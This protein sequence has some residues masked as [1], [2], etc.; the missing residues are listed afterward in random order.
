MITFLNVKSDWR[1]RAVFF[2]S[3]PICVQKNSFDVKPLLQQV[4]LSEW[5]PRLRNRS[6][7]EELLTDVWV[8][9][10]NF[11]AWKNR[12]DP[13]SHL[14][15]FY[16]LSGSFLETHSEI[17]PFDFRLISREIPS[18]STATHFPRRDDSDW[19]AQEEAHIIDRCHAKSFC[20][21][22]RATSRLQLWA[23]L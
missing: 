3:L 23:L 11:G 4:I 5:F 14:W 9:T 19:I 20:V 6:E 13:F 22:S 7:V 16:L 17:R 1:L 18:V 2:E 8:Q 10:W 21:F 15:F 12:R